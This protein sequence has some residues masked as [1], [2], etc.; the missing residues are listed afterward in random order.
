MCVS[1]P[2]TAPSV[3]RILTPNARP[4]F[5]DFQTMKLIST[6]TVNAS[7]TAILL[8]RDN[9][10]LAVTCDDLVLRIVDIE[11]RRI[12]RELS[13]PRGRILDVV[14]GTAETRDIDESQ[15]QSP[16]QAFSPDSRWIIVASQDSVI[17]T[18]DVPTGQLVDAFR[19]RAVATSIT[20]SPTGDFL[21]STH[22]DSVGIYLW[23]VHM[24]P[25]NPRHC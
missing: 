24:V 9:G 8:Q 18:F 23:C 2:E 19:T 12:V 13:G 22:V 6:L 1:V 5:F 4:Q 14:S 17:R 3:A 20:F 11:T 16:P 21:A 25:C 10:L 15:L 7:V